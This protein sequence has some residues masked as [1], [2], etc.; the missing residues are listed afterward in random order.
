MIKAN[1]DTLRRCTGY[2]FLHHLSHFIV[3]HDGIQCPT[4]VGP[5]DLLPHGRQ[6]SLWVE[7][8]GHPE[9]IGAT[10]KQPAVELGVAV[11]KVREPEAE[12]GR[13]PGYL[14]TGQ[15]KVSLW[16]SSEVS[17]MYSEWRGHSPYVSQCQ[18]TISMPLPDTGLGQ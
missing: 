4:L 10:L 8:P 11:K 5:G 1:I 2:I 15:F 18:K 14:K 17:R 3:Q 9:D 7:E 12:C 6:E 13:L 16:V